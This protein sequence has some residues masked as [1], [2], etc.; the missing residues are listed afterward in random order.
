MLCACARAWGFFPLLA[1]LLRLLLLMFLSFL[2]L[3]QK[4]STLERKIIENF[5]AI[6][7]GTVFNNILSFSLVHGSISANIQRK[8]PC[9]ASH[10]YSFCSWFMR[11]ENGDEWGVDGTALFRFLFLS[12]IFFDRSMGSNNLTIVLCIADDG[13]GERRGCVGCVGFC[14]YALVLRIFR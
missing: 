13:R 1:L 12:C 5:L 2:F 6:R 11:R 4:L 3:L 14:C 10:S 9:I 8:I 7:F